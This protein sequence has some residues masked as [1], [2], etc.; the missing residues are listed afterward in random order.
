MVTGWMG[1]SQILPEIQPV[2][3]D[4]IVNN[5]GLLLNIR[6]NIVMCEHS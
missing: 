4:T 5:N 6:L 3:I 2:T 1:L